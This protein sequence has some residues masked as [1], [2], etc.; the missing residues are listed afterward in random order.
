ME[1]GEATFGYVVCS[2]GIVD[3]SEILSGR[4]KGVLKLTVV[5]VAS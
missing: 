1:G 4:P 5:L 2:V 3:F